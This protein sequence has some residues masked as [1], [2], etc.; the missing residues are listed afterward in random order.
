[1]TIAMLLVNTVQAARG[2]NERVLRGKT[3]ER[4]DLRGAPTSG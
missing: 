3:E 4:P 2:R 1:M